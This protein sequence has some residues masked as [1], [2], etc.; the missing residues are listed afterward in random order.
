MLTKRMESLESRV[1]E[2]EERDAVRE[3]RIDALE[4]K[5]YRWVRGGDTCSEAD[6]VSVS[7]V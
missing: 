1:Q 4:E 7:G 2:W 5:F 6:T 3:A